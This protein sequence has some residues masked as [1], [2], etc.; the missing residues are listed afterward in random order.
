MTI[1]FYNIAEEFGC[2]SNFA[3][4][5]IE[6]GG[7]YWPT[8]EHYFQ[9][10]KFTDLSFQ[11]QIANARSP[12]EAFNLGRSRTNP[13]RADWDEFRNEVMLRAVLQKFRTHADIKE[14]LLSTG[15]AKLVEKTTSDY[16]WGCGTEGT[17]NNM[18]GIILME[19]RENIRNGAA[20]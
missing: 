1:Y 5:G 7:R 17:G 2:F 14:I 18:L 10:M 20:K 6:L 19:V 8:T 11:E 12:R 13:I 15:E 4:Y 16:Y 3:R 9:A